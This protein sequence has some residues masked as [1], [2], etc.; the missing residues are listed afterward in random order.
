MKELLDRLIECLNGLIE[1]LR[2]IICSVLT[3]NLQENNM[4]RKSHRDR[5]MDNRNAETAKDSHLGAAAGN[6]IRP[7]DQDGRLGENHNQQASQQQYVAENAGKVLK[8]LE[9]CAKEVEGIKALFG[10]CGDDDPRRKTLFGSLNI[11]RENVRSIQKCLDSNGIGVSSSS[12]RLS[13]TLRSVRTEVTHIKESTA[14]ESTL[15]T[16]I[17]EISVQ[18]SSRIESTRLELIGL[19]NALGGISPKLE[20]LDTALS[21]LQDA[22]SGLSEFADIGFQSVLKSELKPL[23][24]LETV[25]GKVAN[26]ASDIE[27]IRRVLTDKGLEVRQKFPAA[28]ADEEVI[29]QMADYGRT[30]LDQLSVA[31]R[32]YARS[33]TDIDQASDLRAQ[34]EKEHQKGYDEGKEAGKAEGKASFIEELVKRCGDCSSLFIDG[35]DQQNADGRLKILSDLLQGEGLHRGHHK[36]EII[37]VHDEKEAAVLENP[38]HEFPKKVRITNSDFYLGDKLLQKAVWEPADENAPEGA[39]A[40]ESVPEGSPA[41]GNAP[42]GAAADVGASQ[43]SAEQNAAGS[44]GSAPVNG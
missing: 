14:K 19:Q 33:K 27:E 31:A 9:A 13:D 37:E 29:C 12:P 28:S 4:S 7:A 2:Q 10:V 22:Q 42:E 8:K 18:V 36:D 20:K 23:Q 5:K 24:E 41:G 32:W 39:P 25:S 43:N 30:I 26:L 16:V 6:S 17:K 15:N 3:G 44:E 34:A 1:C 38:P 21:K 35:T 11:L 40:G